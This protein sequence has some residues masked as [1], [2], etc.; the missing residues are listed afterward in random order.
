MY[1]FKH[2]KLF[3]LFFSFFINM[4]YSLHTVAI[5]SPILIVSFVDLFNT[6]LQPIHVLWFLSDPGKGDYTVVEGQFVPK[7]PMFIPRA[8]VANYMLS[9]LQRSDCDRKCMAIGEKA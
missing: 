7:A 1:A 8:D 5:Y 4:K 9:S 3:W 2:I 6:E